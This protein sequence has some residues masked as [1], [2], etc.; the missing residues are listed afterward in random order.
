MPGFCTKISRVLSPLKNSS[1]SN[2]PKYTPRCSLPRP[3]SSSRSSLVSALKVCDTSSFSNKN[4][5]A[6]LLLPV[7]AFTYDRLDKNNAVLLVVDHQEGLFQL[8]RDQIPSAYKSS[9]LAHAAL[10]KIFNLPTI[11]TT[12]A[13]QGRVYLDS[14]WIALTT[15]PPLIGPNGPLPLE[16]VNMHPNAT[17]IHRQGEV[18]AWDNADFQAAVKATGKQQVILAGITTDVSHAFSSLL[19][20]SLNDLLY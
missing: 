10:A 14:G 3:S 17:F 9:I 2:V 5:H 16:I 6:D 1:Q 20:I 18:N 8:A 19:Q 12:S 13:D 11:L 4:M 7:L 15:S